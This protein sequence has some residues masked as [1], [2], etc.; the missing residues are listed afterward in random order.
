MSLSVDAFS[1]GN[2][3]ADDNVTRVGVRFREFASQDAGIVPRIAAT[4][5]ERRMDI[6][7]RQHVQHFE[8]CHADA[9]RRQT[10]ER[11]RVGM[12]LRKTRRPDG[13]SAFLDKR[14]EE[15]RRSSNYH[16]GTYCCYFAF[17]QSPIVLR[18]GWHSCFSAYLS[19]I[20]VSKYPQSCADHNSY[21]RPLFPSTV[22]LSRAYSLEYT[23][24]EIAFAGISVFS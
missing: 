7:F 16:D 20:Y 17:F 22:T 12:S 9:D 11:S 18:R 15:Q 24:D 10:S 1:N 19:V 23:L 3:H 4:R 2:G 6:V 14:S 13:A 8:A 21:T 5:K